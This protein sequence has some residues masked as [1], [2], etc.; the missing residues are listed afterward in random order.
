MVSSTLRIAKSCIIISVPFAVT[1]MVCKMDSQP[2][3]FQFSENW[4][5]FISF[6]F[7]IAIL[8]TSFWIMQKLSKIFK[9]NGSLNKNQEK[10]FK[11]KILII[12]CIIKFPRCQILATD[13]G[14]LCK[15]YSQDISRPNFHNF[16]LI[17]IV[18]TQIPYFQLKYQSVNS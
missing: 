1:E 5:M 18:S 8:G 11:K 4:N 2:P 17:S 14:L 9:I 12:F 3:R 10:R 16:N 15:L 7:F 6:F 13:D